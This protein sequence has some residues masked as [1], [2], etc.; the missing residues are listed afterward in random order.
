MEM[1]RKKVKKSK[2]ELICPI[3]FK[4]CMLMGTRDFRRKHKG[5]LCPVIKEDPNEPSDKVLE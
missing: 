5:F 2:A 1:K 4:K 3:L